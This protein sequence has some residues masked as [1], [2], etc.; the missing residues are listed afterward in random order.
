MA[1]DCSLVKRVGSRPTHLI[2]LIGY[3]IVKRSQ[4][5]AGC[6]LGAKVYLATQRLSRLPPGPRTAPP[7]LLTADGGRLTADS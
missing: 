4:T 5:V 1:I 3:L 2:G 6:T 7:A